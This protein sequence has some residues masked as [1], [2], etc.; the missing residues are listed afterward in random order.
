MNDF[1][2][3]AT[4]IIPEV[5]VVR[6]YEETTEHIKQN[7]PEVPVELPSIQYAIEKVISEPSRVERGHQNS[8]IYVHTGMTNRSGDPLRIPVRVVEGTSARVTTAFFATKLET[9]VDIVW[10]RDEHE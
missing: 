10:R 4:S 8:Y 7:H 3:I 5:T 2:V 9:E 1:L 6:L